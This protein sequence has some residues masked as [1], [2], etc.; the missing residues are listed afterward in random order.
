[1]E[2]KELKVVTRLNRRGATDVLIDVMKPLELYREAFK[3]THTVTR[4]KVSFRVPSLE[5]ALAMKFGPMTSRNRDQAKKL[6][7]IHDFIVMVRANAEIDLDRLAQ[8]G[9]MVYAGGGDE[10][11]EFVRKTRTGEQLV[12]KV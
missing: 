5:M 8:L 3:H 2:A 1:L 4:G 7:D 6:V 11:L 10:V 12:V 9:E